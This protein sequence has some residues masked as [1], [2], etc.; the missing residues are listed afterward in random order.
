MINIRSP[1]VVGSLVFNDPILK[2]RLHRRSKFYEHFKK[3]FKKLV[4]LKKLSIGYLFDV[5]QMKYSKNVLEPQ[6]G[7]LNQPGMF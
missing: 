7:I 3:L 1:R 6:T 4:I 2:A 5:S